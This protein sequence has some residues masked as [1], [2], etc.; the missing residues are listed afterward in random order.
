MLSKRCRQALLLKAC[1]FNKRIENKAFDVIQTSMIAEKGKNSLKLRNNF[2]KGF[3]KSL[4]WVCLTGSFMVLL[5]AGTFALLAKVESATPPTIINYQGKLLESNTSVTTTKAMAFL[6]YDSSSGGSLLYTAAGTLLSTSTI[7]VT[8]DQGIFSVNLGGSGTNS[9]DSDIFKDNDSLYLE[10]WIAGQKLTPR[11]RLTSLP[12]AINSQYLMGVSASSTVIAGEYIP[13]AD[14]SGAFTFS[15]ST[16]TSLTT[17]N[18]TSTDLYIDGGINLGGV[19]R[20][21][22]PSGGSGTSE[23]TFAQNYGTNMLTPSS[24]MDVWMQGAAYVSSTLVVEGNT[25]LEGD[26]AVTGNT[27][28]INLSDISGSSTLAYLGGNQTFTGENIFNATTTFTTTTI[29]ST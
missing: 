22:W 18:A 5:L 9:L 2:K 4:L 8:P 27:S 12:Y 7:N 21:T 1:S 25:T 26:L 23:W 28:G 24:T 29:A 15:S 13:M 17:T 16:I 11:K 14:S 6:I 10:I 19:Y 3:K 20:T